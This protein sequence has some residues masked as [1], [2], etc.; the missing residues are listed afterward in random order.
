MNELK[1]EIKEI[2]GDERTDEELNELANDALAKIDWEDSALM[3]KD[4]K[5]LANYYLQARNIA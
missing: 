1:N 4:M 2:L 5:W 3:H